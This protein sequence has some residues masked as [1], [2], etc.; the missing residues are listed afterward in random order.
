[1]KIVTTYFDWLKS[2][3]VAVAMFLPWV[4][5]AKSLGELH[6]LG[7]WLSKH[8]NQTSKAPSDL[9]KDEE[10][11]RHA[12]LQNQTDTDFLLLV[13]GHSCPGLRGFVLF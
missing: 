12:T 11:T 7:C 3:R 2:K 1:M 5:T 9:L 10:T 6:H 13:H 8:A 4:A